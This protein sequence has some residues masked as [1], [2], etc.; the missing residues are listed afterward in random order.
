MNS[1][2]S[3]ISAGQAILFRLAATLGVVFALALLVSYLDRVSGQ[4]VHYPA[5][6]TSPPPG[7]R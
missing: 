3:R 7:A 4:W 1:S 2:R 5:A 6:I